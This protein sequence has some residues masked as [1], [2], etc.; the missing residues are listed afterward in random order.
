MAHFRPLWVAQFHPPRYAHFNPLWVA[1][2][3]RFLHLIVSNKIS[4]KNFDVIIRY[5]MFNNYFDQ[6]VLYKASLPTDFSNFKNSFLE[7]LKL[8]HRKIFQISKGI[9]IFK[10]NSIKKYNTAHEVLPFNSTAA[11]DNTSIGWLFGNL[12]VIERR[13][14]N[15]GFGLKIKSSD[16]MIK[17]I[18]QPVSNYS[19]NSY[20]NRLILGYTRL[21][22]L[23]L[24][25]EIKRFGQNMSPRT[26]YIGDFQE[27]LIL[28]YNEIINLYL[29]EI[30]SHFNNVYNYFSYHLKVKNPLFEF[31]VDSFSF[32]SLPHYQNWF[33]LILLYNNLFSKEIKNDSV[34]SNLEI[35]SFDKLFEVYVFYLIKDVISLTFS[36]SI[37]SQYVNDNNNKLAGKYRFGRNSNQTEISLYYESLPEEIEL[38]TLFTTEDKKYN[39]D[40]VVEFENRGHKEFIILDAKYKNYNNVERY[41]RDVRDLSFKYLHGIGVI[42]NNCKV[43]GLYILN[44]SEREGYKKVFRKKFD[45]LASVV[46]V[47][48]SIGG[49]SIDPK[50][51]DI[52]KNYILDL[53]SKHLELFER[54]VMKS[55]YR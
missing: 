55:D 45:I 27:Y 5:L 49:I 3:S 41:K 38:L 43:S 51:F 28:K 53:I 21:Y 48:P 7:S 39:P 32:V 34:K 33:E 6:A 22:I 19:Y 52:N 29:R 46:P 37:K 12:D 15:S 1:Q 40:Y 26:R 54:R 13:K 30:L 31:P 16:C 24:N 50:N 18:S 17:E 2:Y 23:K 20:E 8:L 4:D 11:V 10:Y 36:E 42:T 9:S 14:N 35:E 47:L 44:V 25:E